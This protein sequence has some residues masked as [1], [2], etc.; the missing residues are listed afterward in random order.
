MYLHRLG[1]HAK[2]VGDAHPRL[3]V[4]LV[5]DGRRA[6]GRLP[7]PPPVPVVDP[8]RVERRRRSRGHAEAAVA[9]R[10]E[11]AS[12]VGRASRARVRTGGAAREPRRRIRGASRTG[13]CMWR[14]AART[15]RATATTCSAARSGFRSPARAHQHARRLADGSRWR[16]FPEVANNDHRGARATMAWP[17][18]NSGAHFDGDGVEDAP[19]VADDRDVRVVVGAARLRP[20]RARDRPSRSPL[21]TS[22]PTS[23]GAS[24]RVSLGAFLGAFLGSHREEDADGGGDGGEAVREYERE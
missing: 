7:V 23:A 22:A 20:R 21:A 17:H 24:P 4:Q 10:V 16:R 14:T 3:R 5:G 15:R 2:V 19:R 12:R 8:R 6:V 9:V 11:P 13:R 18:N 1:Q